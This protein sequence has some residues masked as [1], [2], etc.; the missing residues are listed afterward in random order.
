MEFKWK[1]KET[2]TEK[3]REK[4]SIMQNNKQD[5]PPSAILFLFRAIHPSILLAA[6]V[7]VH[8]LPVGVEWSFKRPSRGKSQVQNGTAF[9]LR[10]ITVSFKERERDRQTESGRE[11]TTIMRSSIQLRRFLLFLSKA[12]VLAQS[13]PVDG[14]LKVR[15]FE[16]D[17]TLNCSSL[18]GPRSS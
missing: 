16:K 9:T 11:I 14:S 13:Q 2:E 12:A 7:E 6:L 18:L 3:K 1:K 4:K 10:L 17:L 15:E 8:S 5:F